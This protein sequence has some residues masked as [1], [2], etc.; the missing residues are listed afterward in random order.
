[1]WKHKGGEGIWSRYVDDATG[2]DTYAEH[3]PK[4]VKQWCGEDTCFFVPTPN[5]REV[6]CKK[7]ANT[8]NFIVGFHVLKDGKLLVSKK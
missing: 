7:C 1:M 3:T 2:R 6:V 8:R 4:L 5:P